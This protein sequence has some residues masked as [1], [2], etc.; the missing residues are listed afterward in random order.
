MSLRSLYNGVLFLSALDLSFLNGLVSFFQAC[1]TSELEGGD[2]AKA[3]KRL[4]VPPL[5][6][7]VWLPRQQQISIFML[8]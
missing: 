2:R 3:M 1:V 5:G 6:D 8:F 7:Q 4:R